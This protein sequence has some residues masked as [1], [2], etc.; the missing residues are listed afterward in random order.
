MASFLA[1]KS[2]VKGSLLDKKTLVELHRLT[3]FGR[4][5]GVADVLAHLEALS[6]ID[7]SVFL[8]NKTTRSVVSSAT[9]ASLPYYDGMKCATCPAPLRH[10]TLTNMGQCINCKKE[11]KLT[12]GS[13][14]GSCV[15]AI[16]ATYDPSSDDDVSL[17]DAM[18]VMQAKKNTCQSCKGHLDGGVRGQKIE[19]WREGFLCASCVV[20]RK[21]ECLAV[22]RDNKEDSFSSCVRNIFY[23][24]HDVSGALQVG[25]GKHKDKTREV[26]CA[27]YGAYI[28]WCRTCSTSPDEMKALLVYA[29]LHDITKL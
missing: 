29:D 15:G 9:E 24:L 25:F 12:T 28:D 11:D 26:V 10:F 19:G 6:N 22:L 20:E 5:R 2:T 13:L 4:E 7:T 1:L 8:Y 16:A 14:K 27:K 23:H 3:V 18:R 21:D 17:Y